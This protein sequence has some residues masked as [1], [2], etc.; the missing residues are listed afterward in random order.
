VIDLPG[1][2]G[3]VDLPALLRDLAGREINEL[4]VEAGYKLNGSFVREGLVDEYLMYMAPQLIGPGQGMAN[5][6][7]LTALSL[8]VKLAFHGV[9]RMGS[10]LRLLLRKG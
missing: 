3:K 7:A 10:D 4:H 2:G 9:D 1:P 8:S 6:P 5:L